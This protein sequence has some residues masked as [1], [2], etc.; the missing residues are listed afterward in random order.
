MLRVIPILMT[1][2]LK[3]F[4][5]KPLSWMSAIWTANG[6]HMS[7]RAGQRVHRVPWPLSGHLLTSGL[8]IVNVNPLR[9]WNPTLSWQGQRGCGRVEGGK[10]AGIC[11]IIGELLKAESGA[12][13]CELHLIL[14]TIWHSRTFPPDWKKGLVIPVWKGR[15]CAYIMCEYQIWLMHGMLL[16]SWPCSLDC[17]H[18]K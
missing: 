12:M 6:C 2:N 18:K 1:S 4:C 17:I 3:K 14:I 7:E 13:I 9:W 15:G 8:Q 10:A 11:N 5:S 16:R